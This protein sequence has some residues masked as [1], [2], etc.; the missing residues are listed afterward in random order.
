MS[1]YSVTS[2]N[3]H[4]FALLLHLRHTRSMTSAGEDLQPNELRLNRKGSANVP[5][6]K[7]TTSRLAPSNCRGIDHILSGSNPRRGIEGRYKTRRSEFTPRRNNVSESSNATPRS[8]GHSHSLPRTPSDALPPSLP[9]TVKR[10]A[11]DLPL[12]LPIP[13]KRPRQNYVAHQPPSLDSGHIAVAKRPPNENSITVDLPFNCWK[14]GEGY[15]KARRNWLG[16]ERTRIEREHKVRLGGLQYLD[17]QVLFF[18][19]VERPPEA[20]CIGNFSF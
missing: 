11:A 12:D 17:R 20:R 15:E 9:G 2:A 16:M 7:V 10:E 18:C 5:F 3:S 13:P 6:V 4:Q 1:V 19:K 8:S 14:G